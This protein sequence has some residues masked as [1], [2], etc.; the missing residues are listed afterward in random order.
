PP[1]DG[2]AAPAEWSALLS[3]TRA[4][5]H[6]SHLRFAAHYATEVDPV[7]RAGRAVLDAAEAWVDPSPCTPETTPAGTPSEPR[8][9]VL[10]GGLGTTHDRASVDRVDVA[11][12]GYETADVIRFSYAGGRTP[13]WA[14]DGP[15][16]GLP[17]TTYASE[18]SQ[19]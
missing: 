15:L 17:V 14:G 9:A 6:R 10:V 1:S 12:L 2:S 7:V 19:G 16:A 5:L 18:D 4:A 8:V 3:T 11:S 13:G